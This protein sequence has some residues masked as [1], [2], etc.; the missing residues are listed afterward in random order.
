MVIG[1]GRSLWME[2]EELW[3]YRAAYCLT[4][5]RRQCGR[6]LGSV[7][8]VICYVIIFSPPHRQSSV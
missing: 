4:G 6:G 7:S 3:L 5:S 2:A 8:E 1:G